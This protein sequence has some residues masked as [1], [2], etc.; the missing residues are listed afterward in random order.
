MENMG[1]RCGPQENERHLTQ[2]EECNA[3]QKKN[4]EGLTQA[5][6]CN[7]F[8]PSVSQNNTVSGTLRRVELQPL[9]KCTV[10]GRG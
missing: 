6:F 9:G 8:I 5:G 2:L 3:I 7:P 4:W 10:L 1:R